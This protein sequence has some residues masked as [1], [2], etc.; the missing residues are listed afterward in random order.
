MLPLLIGL[1]DI[2]GNGLGKVLTELTRS[3]GGH[4]TERSHLALAA[5]LPVVA[6]VVTNRNRVELIGIGL[7]LVKDV[8]ELVVHGL[9]VVLVHHVEVIDA[10][11]IDL[12]Q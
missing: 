1:N 3:I 12:E 5:V 9:E 6:V 7:G 2:V 8:S 10:H 4:E 11:G